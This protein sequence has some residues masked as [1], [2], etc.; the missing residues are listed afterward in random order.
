[1]TVKEAKEYLLGRYLVVGSPANP[2][3]GECEKH[4]AAIDI[5]IA[6]LNTQI[7]QKIMHIKRRPKVVE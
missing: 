5:A 2:P 7:P 1:M 6:A 4:N 3:A